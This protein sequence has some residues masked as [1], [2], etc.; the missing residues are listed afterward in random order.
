MAGH[1]EKWIKHPSSGIIASK[2][3]KKDP[4]PMARRLSPDSIDPFILAYAARLWTIAGLVLAAA[5]LMAVLSNCFH[6]Q[7]ARGTAALII[8]CR[9]SL[10]LSG[11][12]IGSFPAGL[13]RSR[14]P[15]AIAGRCR[16]KWCA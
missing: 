9:P 15:F 2:S 4:K 13:C 12:A 7:L 16:V 11:N 5:G 14:L 6:D 10:Q 3:H 8:S 1:T